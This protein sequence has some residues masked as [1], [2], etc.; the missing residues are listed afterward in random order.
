MMADIV[1][2]TRFAV[3]VAHQQQR[4]ADQ[5]HSEVIPRLDQLLA[6]SD[7]LPCAMKNLLSF[8][9]VYFRIEIEAG[10]EGPCPRDI[11][12][13]AELIKRSV[14][15]ARHKSLAATPFYGKVVSSHHSQ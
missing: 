5:F 9:L 7:Y 12:I 10:R 13:D 14:L 4:F 11:G 1:E 2:T 3:L 8:A 6:M 15:G